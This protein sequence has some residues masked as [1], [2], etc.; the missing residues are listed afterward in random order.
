MVLDHAS[1]HSWRF[2]TG[3][4]E[5]IRCQHHQHHHI[6]LRP[7]Q[8]VTFLTSA[9]FSALLL[10]AALFASANLAMCVRGSV[11]CRIWAWRESGCVRDDGW[12]TRVM[13]CVETPRNDF[14]CT[15]VRS[16]TTTQKTYLRCDCR[17]PKQNCWN[18]C[19][20]LRAISARARV[21]SA[22]K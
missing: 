2:S 12:I 10:C 9:G 5:Q 18:K 16:G 21:P 11:H 15:M 19:Q 22:T 7:I 17:F 1:I 14:R 3:N 8:L 20:T 13:M 4:R 6:W